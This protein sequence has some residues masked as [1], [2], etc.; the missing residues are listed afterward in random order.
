MKHSRQQASLLHFQHI[1][2]FCCRLP[3]P[4]SV[5]GLGEFGILGLYHMTRTENELILT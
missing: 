4:T 3:N 5:F 1:K 2:M